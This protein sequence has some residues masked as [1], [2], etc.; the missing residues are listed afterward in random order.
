MILKYK[1]LFK[2]WVEG[3]QDL[4]IEFGLNWDQNDDTHI[5][6][7]SRDVLFLNVGTHLF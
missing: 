6:W 4:W 5:K 3:G 1:N 2:D 7:L